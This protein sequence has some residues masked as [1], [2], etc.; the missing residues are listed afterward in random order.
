VTVEGLRRDTR[1]C[2]PA[3]ERAGRAL[4]AEWLDALGF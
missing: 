2:T 3:M 4:F 1:E